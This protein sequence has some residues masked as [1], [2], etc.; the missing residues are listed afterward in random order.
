MRRESAQAGVAAA[1][2]RYGGTPAPC[3]D[4]AP[5]EVGA[6]TGLRVATRLGPSAIPAAGL[7]RFAL[8]AVPAGTVIRSQRVGSPD[9]LAFRSAEVTRQN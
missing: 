3:D 6:R 7:G 5:C 9:L 4:A 8:E 1:V 2:S